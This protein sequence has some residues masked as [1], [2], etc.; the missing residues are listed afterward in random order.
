MQ[1]VVELPKELAPVQAILAQWLARTQ[2][3][4]DEHLASDLPPVHRLVRHIERY[5]GKMLRP[6]LVILFGMACRA[7]ASSPAAGGGALLEPFAEHAVAA[8]VCEMVHMATLVHDDVLDEADTRRSGQTVNRLHGN[9]AAVI[10]GDLLIAGAYQLCSS[11]PTAESARLVASVSVEMCQGELLQL[12]H[13]DDY[14]LDEATYVEIVARKTAA[15]IGCACHLGALHAGAA[16]HVRRAAEA[17]GRQLGIAF[18]I[19]DDILD[20]TGRSAFLGKPVG[21]DVAK[22]KLTLPLILLLRECGPADRARVVALLQSACGAP[23]ASFQANLQAGSQGSSQA[24][25][26]ATAQAAAE[27]SSVLVRSGSIDRAAAVAQRRVVAAKR[28]LE[29]MTDSP[30]LRMLHVMA[31]A[32]VKRAW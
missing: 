5:R 11:L 17:F 30:A 21:Q 4:F 3:C 15:L 26:Q 22:G 6:S 32:V 7:S 25:A 1:G 19:Q 14:S 9:E 18:Q 12:H 23:P 8:A 16:M 31:D 24:N 2:Q 10:L 29:A 27:L 28:E 20:L 13:R